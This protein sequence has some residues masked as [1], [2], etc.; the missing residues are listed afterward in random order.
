M[1]TQKQQ[2]AERI[3]QANNILVT[4][5]N[6]P[7]VDQLAAC[8]GLTLSL[9]KM[10]KHATAVFSG[11]VPS[12][13]E[14]LQPE[15]TLERNTD[16]LRDFIIALDKSKADKLRYKV[17]DKMVRIFITPYR[18]SINEKDLEF[19]QGDFNVDVVVAIGVHNQ[20][21][22]DQAI[23]T[24]GRILHD[25][26]ILTMNVKPGGEFGSIN[27]LDP[28]ASSL[29]ELGVQLLNLLDKQLMDGQIATSFLTGIVAETD[30]F[31]NSKTSPGTMSI[32]AELMSAGANQQL[33]AT[34]L[35]EP[36]PAPKQAPLAHQE[37]SADAAEIA[38]EKKPDDGTLEIAHEEK[39]G[40]KTES[41]PGAKPTEEKPAKSGEA[42][43]QPAKQQE[44]PTPKSPEAAP[45]PAHE[46]ATLPEPA[47]DMFQPPVAPPAPQVKIDEHGVL[48]SAEAEKAEE[49][50]AEALLP[51]LKAHEP[52]AISHH[53]ES[54]K[55]ALE[56][57]ESGGQLPGGTAGEPGMAGM[58]A[59]EGGL[60]SNM[61]EDL[62]SVSPTV[63]PSAMAE[64]EEAQ[65]APGTSFLGDQPLLP[66]SAPKSP[67]TTPAA[68]LRAEEP[69]PDAAEH[70]QGQDQSVKM[71]DAGETLS[72]IEHDVHS[73]HLASPETPGQAEPAAP[74]VPSAPPP[75]PPA[76]PV[77]DPFTPT[78]TDTMLPPVADGGAT[79]GLPP[80]IP[81]VTPTGGPQTNDSIPDLPVV[82]PTQNP[83]DIVAPTSEQ[84]PA[85]N[86]DNG[87]TVDSARDAVLQAIDGHDNQAL[88]PAQSPATQP[89]D[90]PP[91]GGGD[92]NAASA[93]A[94]Q[95]W[96][97][98][99]EDGNL[100]Q[101]EPAAA[102][103]AAPG[104]DLP[105]PV[106][107]PMMPL[108][109]NQ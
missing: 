33:V 47:P 62:P 13:L 83:S 54:L 5:S 6:N 34:K 68:S 31:S 10:G 77:P 103:P 44:E 18:T 93:P 46:E 52:P 61:Q 86:A 39:E 59:Q 105:P 49:E 87:P 88:D 106:P 101:A 24:H 48:A 14:F 82:S 38:A 43:E 91:L 2:A 94:S 15:K 75:A 76:A 55:M 8:M 104:S 37:P 25:A 51:P 9:N 58:P 100:P 57:P 78:F 72:D 17:E 79:A 21:D 19:S 63:S 11:Q 96:M 29:S 89:V 7:S 3:K 102:Q 4:V 36:A 108:G 20:A 80:A 73:T 109:S 65:N 70:P 56:P 99:D 41:S 35:E 84:A 30:R 90:L 16:S 97:P 64:N 42:A 66:I 81:V 95:P 67:A 40:A 92:P 50:A 27:W 107:P 69:A 53:N 98:P 12:T 45:E 71:P 26:T 22:L 28:N 60:P 23:T 74:A 1:D 85:D 32:S